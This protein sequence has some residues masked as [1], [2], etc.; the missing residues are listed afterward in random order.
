MTSIECEPDTE[1]VLAELLVVQGIQHVLPSEER[2]AEFVARALLSVPSCQQCN[3]C[4]CGRSAPVGNLGDQASTVRELLDCLG[5]KDGLQC[6][7]KCASSSFMIN[8]DEGQI[9]QLVGN[10]LINSVQATNGGGQIEVALEHDGDSVLIVVKDSGPGVRAQD[11]DRLFE[12]LFST[13]AKGTGLGLS[14]C[15]QIAQRH[16][17]DI[18]LVSNNDNGGAI[19]RVELPQ[20]D[21]A[22]C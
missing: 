11:V 19:F 2:A 4:Y 13:K 18:E 15:R 21:M 17:G 3:V 5:A 10:L 9:R 16:G 6:D 20:D 14:V 8:A 7:L 12:P 1:A 22:R